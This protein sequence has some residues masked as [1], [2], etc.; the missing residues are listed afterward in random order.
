MVIA[1]RSARFGQ[2]QINVGIMPGA[3]GTQR[4]SRTI[5]QD[6]PLQT[7]LSLERNARRQ[8]HGLSTGGG[9]GR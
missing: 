1:G 6:A 2:P 5:G 9:M 4:L 3:G 7:M 8:K